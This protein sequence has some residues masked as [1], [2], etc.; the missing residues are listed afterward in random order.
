MERNTSEITDTSNSDQMNSG[1]QKEQ[2][3]SQADTRTI[4]PRT[5]DK[6]IFTQKEGEML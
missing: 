2:P 6:S 4:S 1:D 3:L 5:M